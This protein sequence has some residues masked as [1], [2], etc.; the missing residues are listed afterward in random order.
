MVLEV[1][2]PQLNAVTL[3]S[4][5]KLAALLAGDS[6]AEVFFRAGGA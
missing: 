5:D 3:R 6:D 2:Y 4:T 1:R